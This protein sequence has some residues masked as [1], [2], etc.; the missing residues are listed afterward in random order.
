MRVALSFPMATQLHLG[1][2]KFPTVH[3]HTPFI[4]SFILLLVISTNSRQNR[5]YKDSTLKVVTGTSPAVSFMWQGTPCFCFH[6]SLARR[7]LAI[8]SEDLAQSGH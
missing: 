6:R 5:Q 2:F 4:H 7:S 3:T 8:K 1:F